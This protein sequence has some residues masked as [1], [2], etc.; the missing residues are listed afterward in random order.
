[1]PDGLSCAVCFGGFCPIYTGIIH[2][3][4]FSV[5]LKRILMAGAKQKQVQNQTSGTYS[6]LISATG[7]TAAFLINLA[8]L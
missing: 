8:V 6:L 4:D 2:V 3:S 5:F 1:M 7:L